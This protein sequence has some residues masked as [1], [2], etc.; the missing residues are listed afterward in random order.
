SD[1]DAIAISAGGLVTFSQDVQVEDDIIMDSDGAILS[2]GESNEIQVIHELNSGI[3]VKHNATGDGSTVRVTLETGEENIELDDVIGSLQYRAPAETTGTDAILVAAAI[4]AISEGD[5]SAS[6]N[7]TK[8]S[9]MT[10]VSEA[11]SEAM[12]LSS[13]GSLKFPNKQGGDNILL[14]QTAAAGTDAGDDVTLNGTDGGSSNANSNILMEEAE[15]I[16]TQ[17]DYNTMHRMMGHMDDTA[18]HMFPNKFKLINSSGTVLTT[19][20]CAGTQEGVTT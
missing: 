15:A 1:T 16:T 8:L 20:H 4:E 10:G 13:T 7:A 17:T 9:F 12:S 3:L 2:M 19:Y 11:A 5:F 14:N 18:T 6:N